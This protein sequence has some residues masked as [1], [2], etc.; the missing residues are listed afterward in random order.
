MRF[1]V[2][3]LLTLAVAATAVVAQPSK[4][5]RQLNPDKASIQE[6]KWEELTPVSTETVT[7]AKRFAQGLPP[8]IPKRRN[9][10]T[11]GSAIHAKKGTR[12]ASA[13]RAETSSV[14]PTTSKCNILVKDSST[15]QELGYVSKEWNSFAEYGPLQSSQINAL[16]VSFTS[17]AGAASQ[18][19]LVTTNGKSAA[20]PFLG[21]AVGYG[22]D[23][24]DIGPDSTN[25]LFLVGTTQTPTG[26]LPSTEANNSF[27]EVSGAEAASESGIWSY[28]SASRVFTAWWINSDGSSVKADILWSSQEGN[29]LF[30]L[31]GDSDMFR[32][33][34]GVDAP[35]VTLT[36]VPP[37]TVA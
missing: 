6:V 5:F 23:S 26:S 17:S 10:G 14:P 28:D 12:V 7:N 9:R 19:D 30:T 16:E 4:R 21:A 3:S 33:T 35:E 25:Y 32:S 18:L 31:T 27:S 24:E 37:V 34:F 8:L 11:H 1:S 36:C 20:H 2:S 22:S 29:Q 15:G 13:P